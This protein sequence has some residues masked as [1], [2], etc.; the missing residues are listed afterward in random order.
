MLD[1]IWAQDS[2]AISP[3]FFIN[4][5][6]NLVWSKFILQ[7]RGKLIFVSLAGRLG[8]QHND[9]PPGAAFSS[10]DWMTLLVNRN[11]FLR[12]GDANLSRNEVCHQLNTFYSKLS[13]PIDHIFWCGNCCIVIIFYSTKGI[14]DQSIKVQMF[15]PSIFMVFLFHFVWILSYM[16][17]FN[18]LKF[19]NSYI[20]KASLCFSKLVTMM[21]LW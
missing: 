13:Q 3:T 1:P 14:I 19:W 11:K 9:Q 5:S 17:V 8:V 18:D 10:L 20:S 7:L 4:F 2:N 15:E 12:F 16:K 6:F 21:S